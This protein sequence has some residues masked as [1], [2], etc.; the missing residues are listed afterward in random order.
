MCARICRSWAL[1]PLRKTNFKDC[2]NA[3]S[4]PDRE[5]R[6]TACCSAW[7]GCGT[8]L[9]ARQNVIFQQ[10]FEPLRVCSLRG[11]QGLNRSRPDF[12]NV[13]AN[14]GDP[15]K[16]AATLLTRDALFNKIRVPRLHPYGDRAVQLGKMLREEMIGA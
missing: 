1:R 5:N 8:C 6:Q 3:E 10:G 11:L 4:K 9:Q 16:P 15:Q 2:L 12:G 14:A 13:A 7:Q